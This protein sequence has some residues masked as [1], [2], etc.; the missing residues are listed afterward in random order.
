MDCIVFGP[1]LALGIPVMD[2]SHRIIFNLLDAMQDLPRPVFD[3][4]LRQLAIELTEDLAEENRLMRAINYDATLVH[5]A[6][7]ESLLEATERAQRLLANDDK[8][9]TREIID[10]LANWI[11]AHINTMDLALAVEITKLHCR[12]C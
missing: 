12:K 8:L 3:D 1:N 6:A 2:Q 10:S 5:Q 7:H 9:G 4:A 11:E